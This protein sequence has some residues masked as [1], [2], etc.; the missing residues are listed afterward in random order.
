[1]SALI[2][3]ALIRL[4]GEGDTYR[5]AGVE[6]SVKV[7][8]TD[9]LQQW[10]LM[11]YT[12]PAG[13]SGPGLHYHKIMEEGF[14][15]LE[16]TLTFTIDGEDLELGAGSFLKVPPLAVHAFRNDSDAPAR[17][18]VFMAP[19]GF[20]DY[21]PDLLRLMEQE[22]QWPPRDLGRLHRLLEKHDTFSHT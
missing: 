7:R 21:Y 20:E 3:A 13:F 10:S 1:M 2:E 15:L 16:G 5:F 4:A 17:F 14:Y 6:V 22:E 18:L 8:K 9:S 19:G 12:A 11:E